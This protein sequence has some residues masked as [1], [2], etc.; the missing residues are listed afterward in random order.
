MFSFS[1]IPIITKPTRITDTS[2][3]LLE[4]FFVKDPL[5]FNAG[6]FVC[7][8]SDCFPIYFNIAQT[9]NEVNERC[10]IKFKIRVVNRQS[11]LSFYDAFSGVDFSEI[12]QCEDVDFSICQLDKIIWH[13]FDLHC[14]VKYKQ[15]SYKDA[16]K[17][18]ITVSLKNELKRR[19]N[20][21][22]LRRRVK[23]TDIVF[24]H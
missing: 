16:M 4:N 17:P 7:D 6:I 1:L 18:W 5:C 3:S 14:H 19:N 8:Y 24:K 22:L 21:L 13:C 23:V 10:P 15:V 12:T 2:S 11:L 9:P 20:M